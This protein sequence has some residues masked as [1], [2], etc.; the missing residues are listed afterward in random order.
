M[1]TLEQAVVLLLPTRGPGGK[2]T[3]K[4]ENGLIVLIATAATKFAYAAIDRRSVRFV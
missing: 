3:P 2:A 4:K 1:N